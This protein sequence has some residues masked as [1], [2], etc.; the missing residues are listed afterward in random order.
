[1]STKKKPAVTKKVES[2]VVAPKKS[3]RKYEPPQLLK[4]MK[5]ILPEEQSYRMAILR[6]LEDI[7]IS[8][9]YQRIDTPILEQASLFQRSIGEHTDV[10]EKEMYNFEDKSGDQ[11]ALRPEFTASIARAYIEH[12]MQNR[13]QPVKLYTV[14]PLFRHDRPQAG[15]YRQFWQLDLEVIGEGQPVIDAELISIGYFLFKDLGLDAMVN[16][17][18]IGD[19]QCRPQ[20]IQHLQE[21]FRARRKNL[22]DNCK[23]RLSKNT[24]R[25]LDCKEPACQEIAQDAPQIIDHLCA[26]CRDHFVKVLELLDETQIPYTLN[27]KIV[28]GLDYYSRTAWEFFPVMQGEEQ[29]Q[30]QAALAGG[31][32]YDALLQKLG[33]TQPVPASGFAAG[34]ERLILA[35]KAKNIMLPSLYV[36]DVYL[37]QLGASAQKRSLRLMEQLRQAGFKVWGNLVKESLSAQLKVANKLGVSFTLILGQKELLDG[38][39]IVRDMD[40]NSQEIVD[41]KKIEKELAKRLEKAPV[42]SIPKT[43]GAYDAIAA[44]ID[45]TA[46]I[47]EVV[48]PEI[49]QPGQKT[50]PIVE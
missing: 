9:G 23:L 39:I 1:M 48:T 10:V 16:I 46:I 50:L 35:M 38:T 3:R 17:N 34:I 18:S 47:P 49:V 24:L 15:R 43:V 20:Y 33:A 21:Y 4:G 6:K 14:G 37:A 41:I 22:C 45:E 27:P 25:L 2:P 12:G 28:R 44:N 30:S 7:A 32:R 36:P 40:S 11:V 19:E 26:P 8:Y 42:S 5:D 31:G 29:M 13:T